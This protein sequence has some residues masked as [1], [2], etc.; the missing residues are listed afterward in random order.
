MTDAVSDQFSPRRMARVAGVCALI[1]IV[2]GAF[3]I[4]YVRNTLFV[5][6]DATATARNILAHETLFRAGV[7]AH[8]VLLLCNI[9]AEILFFLL[10]RR[11]NLVVAAVA[12]AC[13]LIGT[14]IESL[15]M[16]NAYVPLQLA[17][18]AHAMGTFT[19]Q[20]IESTSYL[21]LQLQNVGLLISFVFYGLD[22]MLGGF[23]IVRSGFIPRVIGALLAI[24]G[25]C[26]FTHGFLS[27]IAPALDARVYPYILYPC[28]PGEG[29]T[30]LWMATIGLNV[31]R[32][33]AWTDVHRPAIVVPIRAA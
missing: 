24:A 2:T 33:T 14:A 32:W 5:A 31:A 12:M 19:P 1:G 6:G 29:S 15:D 7:G 18:D 9:P 13:G 3:D 16:L 21:A 25:C 27:V 11:V 17:V 28:L 4:G 10:F 8:L 20:Q 22:E 30:A 26:Y 23:L